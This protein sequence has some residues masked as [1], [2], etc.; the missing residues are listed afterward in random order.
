LIY[1]DFIKKSIIIFSVSSGIKFI[2]KGYY[3]KY[4]S[5]Y[6]RRYIQNLPPLAALQAL[7]AEL[8]TSIIDQKTIDSL[9]H[10]NTDFNAAIEEGNYYSALKLLIIFKIFYCTKSITINFNISFFK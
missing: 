3:K 4:N 2:S 8:P 5:K 9:R 6:Y 10:I 7:A 1:I